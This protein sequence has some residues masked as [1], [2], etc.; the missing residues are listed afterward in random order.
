MTPCSISWITDVVFGYKT[1][2]SQ[3]NE[4]H[5]HVQDG[6][7]RFECCFLGNIVLLFE[8]QIASPRRD[9]NPGSSSL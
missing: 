8:R 6:R 4:P 1:R 2:L 9:S 3:L 5:L 7:E